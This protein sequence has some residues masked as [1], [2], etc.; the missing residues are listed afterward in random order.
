VAGRVAVPVVALPVGIYALL[1]SAPSP[2]YN[3]DLL[4]PHPL[5]QEQLRLIVLNM[6]QHPASVFFSD[7]PGLIALAG[8]HTPYD[9]PFTMTALATQGRW[10]ESAFRRMLR[11]GRFGLLVLSCDVI[12]SPQ[13]CRSDIFTP[14]VQDAIRDGYRLLFRDVFY[15]YAPR[16]P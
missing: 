9:D 15:T 2:W 11:E 7:D 5:V 12:N 14:G 13:E 4:V 8:K 3:A 10:D 16:S 1:T 6:R